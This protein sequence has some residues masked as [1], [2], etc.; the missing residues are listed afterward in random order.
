MDKEVVK[1]LIQDECNKKNIAS[2]LLRIL[3][4]EHRLN[5]LKQYDLLEKKLG[6]IGASAKTANLIIKHLT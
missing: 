5:L 6:G 4:P 2:E 3:T 1:E